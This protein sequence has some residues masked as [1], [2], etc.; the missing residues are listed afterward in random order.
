[1][2]I[3]NNVLLFHCIGFSKTSS[4]TRKIQNSSI[5]MKLTKLFAVVI[6]GAAASLSAQTISFTSQSAFLAALNSGFYLQ[7]FSSQTAFA[8]PLASL[9]FSGGTPTFSYSI[10]APASGLFVN[11]DAGGLNAIGNFATS[12]PVLFSFT[13]GNVY[14]V[15]AEY[16]LTD[17]SGN[18]QNGNTSLTFSG[19]ATASVPSSSAVSQS[20]YAFFGLISSSPITSLSVFDGA[21]AH[22]VNVANL[23]VGVAPVPEPGT[24]ALLATGIAGLALIR[25]R[26]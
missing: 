19:G 1:M 3:A 13:S 7:N 2:R 6:T 12:D 5:T 26:K 20:P 10:T 15:G 22:F 24:A 11:Q 18:P 16:Y 4:V 9:S 25:R 21:T 14:A 8:G 23:Y 17:I